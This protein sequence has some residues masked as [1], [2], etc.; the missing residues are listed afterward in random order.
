MCK[1]TYGPF[2]YLMLFIYDLDLFFFI[3]CQKNFDSF[4]SFLSTPSTLKIIDCS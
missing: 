1:Y 3:V 4:L 2:S